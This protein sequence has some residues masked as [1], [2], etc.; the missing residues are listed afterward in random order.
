MNPRIISLPLDLFRYEMITTLA[1]ISD[2]TIHA[3]VDDIFMPL[4]RASAS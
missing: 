3:I 1:P 4:V 2:E